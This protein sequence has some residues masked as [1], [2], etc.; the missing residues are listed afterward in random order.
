MRLRNQCQILVQSQRVFHVEHFTCFYLQ[1]ENM[2]HVEHIMGGLEARPDSPGIHKNGEVFHVE[3]S[4]SY[5]RI[6]RLNALFPCDSYNG[7]KL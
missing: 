7:S 2:F 4:V 1:L 3:H 6:M 5:R